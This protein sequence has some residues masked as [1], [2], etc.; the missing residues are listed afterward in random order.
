MVKACCAVL[1]LLL[2]V[3]ARGESTLEK[4]VLTEL[5]LARTNPRAYAGYLREHR[6]LY[7]GEE[8]ML[9]DSRTRIATREG[10]AAVDEAIRFLDRQKALPALAWSEGL[11]EAAGELAREQGASGLTGHVGKSGDMKERIER[12]GEWRERIGEN[13][14]YGPDDPRWVVMQLIIDDGVG[15][16]GH[17]RNIFEPLFRR[18]GVACGPHE[19]FG[20]VCVTDF[21]GGFSR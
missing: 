3:N 11:A 17:R 6:K 13:I 10:K 16:R 14:S 4:G 1:M 12:R 9:K 21:A 7:R 18:G 15:G 20:T 5:N 19:R 2:A 8:I